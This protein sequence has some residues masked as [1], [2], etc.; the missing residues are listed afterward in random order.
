MAKEI[1]SRQRE[2]PAAKQRDSWQNKK[3]RG[4]SKS[5]TAKR[6]A[7]RQ[8]KYPDGPHGIKESVGTGASCR[9]AP[10][11]L[12]RVVLFCFA[13]RL[14]FLPWGYS[15]CL[16][17]ISFA[18]VFYYCREVISFAVTLVGHR[19]KYMNDV[20]FHYTSNSLVRT[21][22]LM[23]NYFPVCSVYFLIKCVSFLLCSGI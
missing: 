9:G 18:R 6:I 20:E 19:N 10:V 5:L 11:F 12:S 13:V 4:K 1:T 7:T 17:V 8:K 15:F 23:A 21:P 16:E 3:T 2:K 14:L 22:W